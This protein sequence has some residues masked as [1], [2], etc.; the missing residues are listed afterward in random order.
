MSYTTD[1]LKFLE[2]EKIL[3]HQSCVKINLDA[4]VWINSLDESW[5][6]HV[7]EAVAVASNLS[8]EEILSRIMQKSPLME[9]MRYCNVGTPEKIMIDLRAQ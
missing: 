3:D 4:N 9:T 6:D 5:Y 2:E 1:I 8:Q 7:L